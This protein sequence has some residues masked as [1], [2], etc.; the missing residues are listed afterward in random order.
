MAELAAVSAVASIT[1][2][3]ELT[4]KVIMRLDEYRKNR[5]DVPKAFQHISR[6][7][8]ILQYTVRQLRGPLETDSIDPSTKDAILPAIAE[9]LEIIQ[10]LNLALEKLTPGV[11]DSWR[12]KQAKAI[13]S[14]YLDSDIEKDIKKVR[15]L[16]RDLVFVSLTIK[17]F[18]DTRL[19]RLRTWVAS[20]AAVD[21]SV[22][23]WTNQEKRHQG[24]GEWFLQSDQYKEWL[25]GPHSLL[26]LHGI[27]GCGKSVLSSSIVEDIKIRSEKDL[28]RNFAFFFFTF[29]NDA[30]RDPH[31]MVTSLIVQLVPQCITISTELDSLYTSCGNGAR[32]PSP[33]VARKLLHLVLQ[34]LPEVYIV[35]DALDECQHPEGLIKALSSVIEWELTNLHLLFTSRREQMLTKYLSSVLQPAQV[36]G[37]QNH[38]VDEDIQR[39]IQHKLAQSNWRDDAQACREIEAEISC[40]SQG[41]FRWA[42]FQIDALCECL[43]KTQLRETLKTLPRDLDETYERM[44]LSIKDRNRQYAMTILKWLTFATRPLRL[45]D[46]AEAVTI[47]YRREPAVDEDDRLRNPLD[48]LWMCTGLV[49]PLSSQAGV[50]HEGPGSIVPLTTTLADRSNMTVDSS[51]L[52]ALSH[53]SVQEYLVSDRIRDGPAKDFYMDQTNANESLA[54]CCISYL[55]HFQRNTPLEEW[56]LHYTRSG[57]LQYCLRFC[58]FHVKEAEPNKLGILQL[59]K[60]LLLSDKIFLQWCR[61]TWYL[62]YPNISVPY[63]HIIERTKPRNNEI[64]EP[65]LQAAILGLPSLVEFMLSSDPCLVSISNS[66]ST[67]P[68]DGRVVVFR[69]ARELLIPLGVACVVPLLYLTNETSGQFYASLA[70]LIIA[71][72]SSIS[73]RPKPRPMTLFANAITEGGE[74]VLG[75]A[76]CSGSVPTLD[77]LLEAGALIDYIDKDPYHT[78]IVATVQANHLEVLKRLIK[79]GASL[80]FGEALAVSL[81]H[82]SLPLI[83]TLLDSEHGFVAF[84]TYVPDTWSKIRLWEP[85][86]G[87]ASVLHFIAAYGFQTYLDDVLEDVDETL[88]LLM[89]R[90]ARAYINTPNGEGL[91]P[92]HLATTR[93]SGF[94]VRPTIKLVECLCREGACMTTR[95][96]SGATA[97]HL[98]VIDS[99]SQYNLNHSKNTSRVEAILRALISN[100]LDVNEQDIRGR[101]ALHLA[102]WNVSVLRAVLLNSPAI[103]QCDCNGNTPLH[104]ATLLWNAPA[105]D[106]LLEHGADINARNE[107]GLTPLHLSCRHGL[108]T[109]KD[110]WPQDPWPEE[111]PWPF[112]EEY[113]RGKRPVLDAITVLCHRAADMNTTDQDGDTLLHVAVMNAS[114]FVIDSILIHGAKVNAENANG[115]TPLDLIQE[116]C[117]PPRD[118]LGERSQLDHAWNSE[119]M[120]LSLKRRVLLKHGALTSSALRNNEGMPQAATEGTGNT[121]L[122]TE[123]DIAT[124]DE[125]STSLRMETHTSIPEITVVPILGVSGAAKEPIQERCALAT[126]SEN[127]LHR[128]GETYKRR[129]SV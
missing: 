98:L 10:S 119:Q 105:M 33:L 37:L 63:G 104:L 84:E 116:T 120:M 101:T 17:N 14:L 59:V 20:F 72:V 52:L 67:I 56:T 16:V 96:V 24:S 103:N 113:K 38:V 129:E 64:P 71:I 15:Q 111:F 79:A 54:G 22:I 3:V 109:L 76:C 44:L 127:D 83:Q 45:S 7:L 115:L 65:L 125:V 69:D 94:D 78:P 95:N 51:S 25:T 40:K 19:V 49:A 8:P 122:P 90:G 35:L 88:Q 77:V 1:Q 53:F 57:L 86:A 48:I 32:K 18:Q 29:R 114:P 26:W 85:K 107:Q 43:T 121:C 102:C 58:E 112:R 31:E 28:D 87:M 89:S 30:L 50:P 13:Q 99:C 74:T 117:A 128:G 73:V 118:V 42:S 124:E 97:A 70:L 108:I 110:K 5:K 106:L 34:A 80:R 23:L 123:V 68:F 39:F 46:L 126:V 11:T 66:P 6:E 62:E 93:P 82:G 60:Q 9:C 41:M 36:I 61:N 81:V 27:P 21:S 12:R 91:T 75:L 47:D 100:G 4:V 2:L 55:L 92:L